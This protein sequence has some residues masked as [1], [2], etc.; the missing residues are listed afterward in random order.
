MVRLLLRS[1][2]I[3]KAESEADRAADTAE[4]CIRRFGPSVELLGPAEA[5]IGMI[6][7]N[8]RWQL[9]LRGPDFREVH[10]VAAAVRDMFEPISGVYL[11]IDI[12][13]LN[14]M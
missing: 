1:R 11:E 6:A 8:S 12:D 9:M 3:T 4:E 10:A 5:P 13:P 7:G 2:S 14:L